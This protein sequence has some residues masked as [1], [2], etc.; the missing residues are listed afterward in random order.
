VTE[1]TARPT[2]SVV[3]PCYNEEPNLRRGVLSPALA[4]AEANADVCE[5]L[6]VDDGSLDRSVE[7]ASALAEA[8]PKLR[9]LRESHRGKAGALL[10][11]AVAAAGDYVLFL[12]LDQATPLSELT[13]L[14]AHLAAGIDVVVGSRSTHREGAPLFRRLMARGYILIRQLIL[15]IG[16]ITDTQCGFKAFRREAFADIR[17]HLRVYQAVGQ[18]RDATV[19]AAFDAELLYV[20]RRLGYTTRE[21]P[22]AWRHV[23]TRRVHPIKEPWRGIKGLLLI[24]Y[25]ALLGRYSGKVLGPAR[26]KS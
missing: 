25:N 13:R 19:A 15:D 16:D 10:A 11:G 5:V 9:L 26:G 23:G 17:K 24:R 14:R 8:H 6:V 1:T 4:F 21:V 18:T 7:L 2:V 20:A 3:V 12:D 22:V